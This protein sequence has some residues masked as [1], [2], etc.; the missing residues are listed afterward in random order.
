MHKKRSSMISPCISGECTSE[1][2]IPEEE[3]S[4]TIKPKTNKISHDDV[5]YKMMKAWKQQVYRDKKDRK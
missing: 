4:K 5:M 3:T 2:D 1:D